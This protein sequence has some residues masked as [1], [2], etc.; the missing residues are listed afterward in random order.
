VNSASSFRPRTWPRFVLVQAAQILPLLLLFVGTPAAVWTAALIGSII[1]CYGTDSPW[2]W[3][4]RLLILQAVCW[5]LIPS[6]FQ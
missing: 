6:F 3:R 1:C 5:L 4:N 2:R